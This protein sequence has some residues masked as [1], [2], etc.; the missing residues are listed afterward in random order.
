MV[1]LR[2]TA[3]SDFIAVGISA[4][5]ALLAIWSRKTLCAD[6]STARRVEEN[7]L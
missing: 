2:R 7:M 5:G 3:V 1:V 4:L 6:W